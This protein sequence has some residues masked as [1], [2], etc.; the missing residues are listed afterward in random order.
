MHSEAYFAANTDC[1]V[2][3]ENDN[4]TDGQQNDFEINNSSIDLDLYAAGYVG[5][6]RICRLLYLAEHC[7]PLRIDALRM[8]LGYIMETYNTNLYTTVHKQ[9]VDAHTKQLVNRP[10]FLVNNT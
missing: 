2:N 5:Y 3:E 9:M 10:A 4:E 1:S 7:P 6:M 8:A